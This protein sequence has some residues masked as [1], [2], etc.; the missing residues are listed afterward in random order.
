MTKTYYTARSKEAIILAARADRAAV[1]KDNEMSEEELTALER[2]YN[3]HGSSGLRA[4]AVQQVRRNTM[5][6]KLQCNAI[7][8]RRDSELR[9]TGR[10]R[11]GFERELKRDR[12]KR[13]VKTNNLCAKH[14]KMRDEG[15]HVGWYEKD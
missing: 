3:A 15:R 4:T 2:D 1:L 12:C 13:T 9:Y 8:W 5:I 14:A 6:V 10:G 7:V 11:G